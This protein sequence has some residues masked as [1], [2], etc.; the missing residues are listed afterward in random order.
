MTGDAAEA[1]DI[2]QETFV[3]ALATPPRDISEPWRPWLVRVAM[4]LARDHLRRRRRTYP[5]EWLPSPIADEEVEGRAGVATAAEEFDS[6][7]AR[8]DR[9][10]SVT[11]AFLLAL[12]ALSPAQR[13][14]LLLRDVFDYSTG[15]SANALG[16]TETNV[17]VT[18]HRARRRLRGYEAGRVPITRDL[19][20]RARRA[21]ERFLECLE[22]RDVAGLE[23]LL[24]EDV[25]VVSDG[26]GQVVALHVPMRGRASVIRLVTRLDEVYR[27]VTR[28]TLRMLNHFP[29]VVAE[30][31]GV[32]E[33]HARRFTLHCELDE[34][35]RI[36]RL[37]FVFAPSKLVAVR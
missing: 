1:E 29:A 9:V 36:S 28:T 14:V 34:E 17:K 37:H 32:R 2:V 7:C 22:R 23:R 26:G 15:E 30:R 21:L 4:N 12:E 33:G 31:D 6:P 20:D 27:D 10:E 35:G 16:M 25:V 8:Y 3:R 11:F 19:S 24:A 18:L 13:A 5:G